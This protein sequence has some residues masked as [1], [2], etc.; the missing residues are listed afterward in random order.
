MDNKKIG[1]ILILI[2]VLIGILFI[3]LIDRL[4][5][6]S[7]EIG[8]FTDERCIPVESSISI[9]HFGFGIIG[10]ILAL[11]VYLIFF[12][13]SEKAI[14]QRLEENK[15][16]ELGNSKFE[17]LL[18]GLDEFERKVIKAI[19]EQQGITQNTITIRTNLSKAKISQ[20]VNS[21]EKKQLVKREKKG[22][23][24]ALYYRESF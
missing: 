17:I 10:F 11:G 1:I 13:S 16:K 20:V 21:L 15:N 3:N 7:S 8:C 4:Y 9:T 12:N 14:L 22:K 19:R 23:T 2:A 18:S 5:E 6:K 24:F